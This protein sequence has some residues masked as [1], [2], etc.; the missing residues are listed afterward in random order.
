MSSS[1]DAPESQND[2]SGK[3][4]QGK[5]ES[6]SIK[7][8]LL[9]NDGDFSTVLAKRT[10]QAGKLLKAFCDARG[11]SRS[12]YRLVY[13]KKVLDENAEIGQYGVEDDSVLNVLA[14]QTG[15]GF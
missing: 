3:Q 7:V 1:N 13:N 12:E 4:S 14:S 11:V 6:P 8:K 2:N 5:K 10:T 9:G 15:G